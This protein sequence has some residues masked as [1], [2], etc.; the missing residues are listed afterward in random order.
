MRY[1]QYCYTLVHIL[2]II[3]ND[4]LENQAKPTTT[5]IKYIHCQDKK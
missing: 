4:K 5:A 1:N 2:V 3:T